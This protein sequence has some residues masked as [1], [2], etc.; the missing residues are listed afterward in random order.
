MHFSES[1]HA[2]YEM[3]NALT[4]VENR[5]KEFLKNVESLKQKVRVSQER[6]VEQAEVVLQRTPL[7][8]KPRKVPTNIDEE[9]PVLN[10]TTLPSP[11]KPEVLSILK[12]PSSDQSEFVNPTEPADNADVQS[13]TPAAFSDILEASIS[14]PSVSTSTTHI[15]NDVPC[16][17]SVG[18]EKQ[19]SGNSED[20]QSGDSS[21]QNILDE[22]PSASDDC[23]A[24]TEINQ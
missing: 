13:H 15:E 19:N 10:E 6:I 18:D 5:Q 23:T 4:E 2:M 9:D 3:S 8:F 14:Q 17:A 1:L 21:T 24:I 7:T 22:T 16:P 12:E 11:L 20:M